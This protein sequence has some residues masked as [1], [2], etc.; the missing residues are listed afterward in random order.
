MSLQYQL[1][2]HLGFNTAPWPRYQYTWLELLVIWCNGNFVLKHNDYN[3]R[4]FMLHIE[5]NS[6]CFT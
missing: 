2:I 1:D 3:V 4:H 6:T 5:Q